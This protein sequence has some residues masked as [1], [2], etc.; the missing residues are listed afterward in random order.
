MK[1]ICLVLTVLSMAVLT[2]C[3]DEDK[4]A[5]HRY[6]DWHDISSMDR[7]NSVE[8][9]FNYDPQNDYMYYI[10]ERQSVIGAQLSRAETY[11][12]PEGAIS[13]TEDF[14]QQDCDWGEGSCDSRVRF[15]LANTSG[16]VIVAYHSASVNGGHSWFRD[17]LHTD[18]FG[19]EQYIVAGTRYE[20]RDFGLTWTDMEMELDAHHRF[21]NGADV[22]AGTV[23]RE[24]STSFWITTDKGNHW[25]EHSEVSGVPTMHPLGDLIAL[26]DESE[27]AIHYSED[28]GTTW[29]LLDVSYAA[30]KSVW[31]DGRRL[32][33]LG[34]NSVHLA[35][36]QDDGTLSELVQLGSTFDSF[37]GIG[38]EAPVTV[39][40]EFMKEMAFVSF[41]N[42]RVAIAK[43]Q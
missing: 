9:K 29:H 42:G 34:E 30:F 27:H 5:D 20:S 36:I 33:F 31:T 10:S 41:T 40:M 38:G 16:D 18:A 37:Q 12:T 32:Y 22:Y 8:Y 7:Q 23:T 14:V 4:N 2:G 3:E 11:W 21:F 35:M 25:I 17:P 6:K 13:Y 43:P 24:D 28:L 26:Y 39:S 1:K 15:E 19:D